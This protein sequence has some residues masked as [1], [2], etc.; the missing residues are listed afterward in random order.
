[1]MITHANSFVIG[2]SVIKT[3]FYLLLQKQQPS[4]RYIPIGYV[5]PYGTMMILLPLWLTW[6][7]AKHFTVQPLS[8]GCTVAF[9]ITPRDSRVASPRVIT[10]QLYQSPWIHKF[11]Y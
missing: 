8:V 4:H 3:H 11:D 1:M 6:W 5:P 10:F 9:S 7:C 2:P